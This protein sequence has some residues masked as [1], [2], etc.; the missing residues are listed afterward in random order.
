MTLE[1]KTLLSN[2]FSE[3]V[4]RTS[5]ITQMNPEDACAAINADGY[6]F[7]PNELRE[8]ASDL[9]RVCCGGGDDELTEEQL[10]NVS[11]GAIAP[12]G[13]ITISPFVVK[14]ANWLI[15]KL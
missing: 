1:R 2:Y 7:T 9:V 10:G 15:S 13:P 12:Y 8:F 3:D 11:G 4:E 14:I 6:D 5:V